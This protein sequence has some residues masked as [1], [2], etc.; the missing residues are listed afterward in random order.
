MYEKTKTAIE[1][2]DLPFMGV[3]DFV[4]EQLKK[5]NEQHDQ[6]KIQKEETEK[7]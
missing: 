7:S 5:L 4:E 2:L 6:W 1:D 3:D